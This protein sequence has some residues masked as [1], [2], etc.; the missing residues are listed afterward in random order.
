MHRPVIEMQHNA[1][2]AFVELM[3]GP[4]RLVKSHAFSGTPF[5]PARIATGLSDGYRLRSS[6]PRVSA[7]AAV[8]GSVAGQS[9]SL[10][11]VE[12]LKKATKDKSV[13]G[14]QLLSA[15]V[16]IEKQKL[17]MSSLAEII[18]GQGKKGGKRWRLVFTA[19]KEAVNK[20]TKG[21]KAGGLYFPIPAVQRWDTDAGEIENGTYFG[22][23]AAL[24]FKGPF[25]ISGKK[26]SFDF[27]KL[28]LRLGPKW[29]EIGLKP[30]QLGT[31]KAEEDKKGPFFLF[32]YAD[33]DILVARGRGGGVAYWQ[34]VTPTWEAESGVNL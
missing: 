23:I 4:L 7:Q 22:L 25:E 34:A 20:A 21:E 16:S 33:D 11:E 19:G 1:R 8:S 5:R 13:P 29:F 6:T 14:G 31:K 12:L 15:I 10:P 2:A 9:T 17:D 26:L 28:R 3:H 32:S 30:G 18:G 27:H 24:T